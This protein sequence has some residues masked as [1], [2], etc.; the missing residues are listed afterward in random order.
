M[1]GADRRDTSP[2]SDSRPTRSSAPRDP[3]RGPPGAR[4]FVL[5]GSQPGSGHASAPHT[6]LGGSPLT[7]SPRVRASWLDPDGSLAEEAAIETEDFGAALREQAAASRTARAAAAQQ[8]TTPPVSTARSAQPAPAT[9]LALVTPATAAPVTATTPVVAPAPV[10]VPATAVAPTGNIAFQ[11]L[12]VTTATPWTVDDDNDMPSISKE[13]QDIDK[14]RADGSNW[15][16]F[17]TRITF[18]A[19]A[20]SLEPVLKAETA[21][22]KTDAEKRLEQEQAAAQLVNAIV[23]KLPDALLRKY[24]KYS[25]PDQVWTALKVEFGKVSIAA[26][27]AIE[28]QMFAL[29]C[30]PNGNMQKYIDRMLEYDQQLSEAG[31]M[32]HILSNKS[33]WC[34]VQASLTFDVRSTS[35]QCTSVKSMSGQHASV[36]LTSGQRASVS[37]TSGQCKVAKLM[38]GLLYEV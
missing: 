24:M 3:S 28:A 16:I 27:A 31:V 2:P 33:I 35:D 4:P 11:P 14:L 10:V 23:Q 18:A 37:L 1:S 29:T 8:I 12:A 15:R 25:R 38:S 13:F 32:G 30:K 26:T 36:H 9:A 34:Q 19:R 21:W 5:T 17:E 7:G 6:P 22:N 20:M